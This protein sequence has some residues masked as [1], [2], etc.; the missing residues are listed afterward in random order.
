MIRTVAIQLQIKHITNSDIHNSKETLIPPL[1]LALVKYLYGD[2]GRLLDRSGI[3][4]HLVSDS[5]KARQVQ[6]TCQRSR[7]SKD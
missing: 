6:L 7:S 1:K 4:D 3:R 5:V 2:H